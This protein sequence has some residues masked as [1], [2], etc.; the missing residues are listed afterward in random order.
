MVA[1]FGE[2]AVFVLSV[3]GF[4]PRFEPPPLPV[5]TPQRLALSILDTDYARIRV[6]AYFAVTS[7]TLQFGAR[8]QVFFGFDA[9]NVNG[10]IGFDALIQF[11]PFYFIVEISASF[12]VSVFG[13]GLLSVRVRMSL[14]GPT[15]WRA[16]GTGSV[17]LL[18]FDVEVDFDETWGEE[19]D[20]E[21][22]PVSVMPLLDAEF[23]KAECWR[24][25]PPGN[26]ADLLVS[27]RRMDPAAEADA[28][29]LHPRGTL[30]VTQRAVPLDLTI[31]RVG[32]RR[33]SDAKRFTLQPGAG[34]S[35]RTDLSENFAPAQFLPLTE[36][37]K[38]T[39]PSFERQH[40]GVELAPAGND[41]AS[42]A[43]VKRINR[44]ELITIDTAY[45][46]LPKRLHALNGVLFAHFLGGASIAHSSLSQHVKTTMQ[47]FTETIAVSGE[48][49]AVALQ[50][51][52]TATAMFAS[53]ASAR[54][55]LAGRIEDDPNAAEE[56]H[57]IPAFELAA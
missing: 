22:E 30:Q 31:D 34:L 50:S 47:P 45:R 33:A 7:N 57:V 23:D 26:N 54:D 39:R 24:A 20:T 13:I 4:H 43:M 19:H 29:V 15:P 10:E 42:A 5:P 56:L 35:K 6:E 51:T 32:T 18:F 3:G 46:R 12:S 38:L 37:E 21:L 36:T 25:L 2:D 11:S 8:A 17:S 53:E 40:G 14:E 27:L 41:M 44:F 48:G 9:M 16:R 49:F 55:F 28:L 1:A 52:N